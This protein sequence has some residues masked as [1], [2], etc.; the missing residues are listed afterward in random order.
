MTFLEQWVDNDYNPFILFNTNGKILSLNQEAQFLLGEVS[1]RELFELVTNYANIT[2]GFKTTLQ[3]IEFGMYKI[4]GFTIGY[5]NENSIGIKLYK[6]PQQTFDE[7]KPHGNKTNIYAILDLC[8]S[9]TATTHDIEFT[10]KFDPSFPTIFLDVENFTKLL[11]KTYAS[12]HN[13]RTISTTLKLK[14]GEYIRYKNKKYPIFTIEIEGEKKERDFEHSITNFSKKT[15]SIVKFF[16][17]KTLIDTPLI[18][19]F[20]EK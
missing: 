18:A 6:Y 5:E 13:S 20:D 14:T 15:G 17:Q 16:R 3:D 11:T 7:P 4:F 2:Y 10:K 19:T 8:I 1:E 9:A 12:Y